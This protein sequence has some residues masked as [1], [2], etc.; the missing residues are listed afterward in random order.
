MP[1]EGDSVSL[2]VCFRMENIPGASQRERSVVRDEDKD[3]EI[4]FSQ[5][6]DIKQGLE[7][8]EP[9]GMTTH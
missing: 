7:D 1:T 6:E 8:C 9:S 4:L 5:E 2:F 3:D